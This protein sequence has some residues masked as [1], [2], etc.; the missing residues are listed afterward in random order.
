MVPLKR[1]INNSCWT[2]KVH[3]TRIASGQ[4]T[5]LT[6]RLPQHSGGA[7]AFSNSTGTPGKIQAGFSLGTS[8]KQIQNIIM[9]VSYVVGVVCLL[10]GI[11]VRVLW[12]FQLALTH[13]HSSWFI[14]SGAF[15]L[16]AL[17]SYRLSRPEVG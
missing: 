17:A 10:G 1:D 3:P 13:S 6:S 5:Y 15:F 12:Q 14:A 16:C 8:M 4:F 11:V 7:A 9:Q 2:A